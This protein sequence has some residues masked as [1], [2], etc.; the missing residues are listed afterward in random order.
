MKDISFEI[1]EEYPTTL[2]AV[3]VLAVELI[4]ATY[5]LVVGAR[6]THFHEGFMKKFEDE[7][8]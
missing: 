5:F 6:I 1:P 3:S 7:H 4:L 8:K 2:L